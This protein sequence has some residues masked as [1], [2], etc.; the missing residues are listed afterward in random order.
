MLIFCNK[1][2]LWPRHK[3]VIVVLHLIVFRKAVQ[4]SM[5]HIKEV[6]YLK[7]KYNVNMKK[8]K[9]KKHKVPLPYVLTPWF[10][11]QCE[12][13]SP[14]SCK[15]RW[16]VLQQLL[17]FTK[18]WLVAMRSHRLNCFSLAS[19]LV[20]IIIELVFYHKYNL[21]TFLNLLKA[22]RWIPQ[23]KRKYIT[24]VY[25]VALFFRNNF[26]CWL[27]GVLQVTSQILTST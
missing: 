9:D 1:R 8:Q 5:L 26:G 14:L 15:A 18:P 22:K 17:N 19:K 4:I 21:Q 3:M 10:G 27:L 16:R 2:K 13:R 7:K 24:P 11:K 12:G 20:L 25:S 23:Y 6:T